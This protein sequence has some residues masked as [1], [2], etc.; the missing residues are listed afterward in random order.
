MEGSGGFCRFVPRPLLSL[1]VA[2]TTQTAAP[3]HHPSLRATCR[4]RAGNVSATGLAFLKSSIFFF[5]KH[6]DRPRHRTK[7][8]SSNIF[9][10][11][12]QHHFDSQSRVFILVSKFHGLGERTVWSYLS[13]AKRGLDTGSFHQVT[14]VY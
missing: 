4:S 3:V 12:A 10:L 7:K 11:D 6:P 14:G 8:L 2:A 13:P 1:L 5:F 9:L